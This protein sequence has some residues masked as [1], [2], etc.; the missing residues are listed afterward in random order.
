MKKKIA[1]K[2]NTRITNDLAVSSSYNILESRLSGELTKFHSFA[3]GKP[4]L[5]AH[6]IENSSGNRLWVLV[7]DWRAN[8]DYY[9]SIYPEKSHK[10]VYAELHNDI[11]NVDQSQ[12]SWKY[13]PSKRDG[14][15]P[16]RK[17]AF[18]K[19]CGGLELT[20][21]LPGPDLSANE[22]MD[23][24]FVL[25]EARLAA[26]EFIDDPKKL[27]SSVHLEGR[28]VWKTHK[29]IERSSKAAKNAKTAYIASNHGKCPCEV[30]GF[31]FQEKY[32]SIGE[33]F[34]EAHHKVPL[35]KLAEGE[36]RDTISSDFLMLCANC[37]RMAHKTEAGESIENLRAFLQP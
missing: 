1:K 20:V 25:I 16:S 21:S 27:S 23:D 12:L 9:V 14:Q 11:K 30:C 35:S 29:R 10:G 2:L 37:H 22:F 31:D 4:C 33:G 6:L 13:S 17:D 5:G 19:L 15:N 28:R 24:I 36:Q 34:I 26:D 7:I 32:G 8:G 3:D 18:Q